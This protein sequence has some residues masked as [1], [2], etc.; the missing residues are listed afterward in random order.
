[1]STFNL[2]PPLHTKIGVIM[3]SSLM[4]CWWTHGKGSLSVYGVDMYIGEIILVNSIN[5][6]LQCVMACKHSQQCGD[7]LESTS[8]FLCRCAGDCYEEGTLDHLG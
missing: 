3:H 5:N 8:C 7:I 1:M 2:T 6:R 4:L